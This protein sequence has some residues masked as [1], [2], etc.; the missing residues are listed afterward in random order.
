MAEKGIRL[1]PKHGVNPSVGICFYCGK[2]D[3]TVVLPGMLKGDVEA[4]REAVWTREPCADCKGWMGKGVILVG[5]RDGQPKSD[6]PDRSGHFT[7]ITEDGVRRAFPTEFADQLLKTRFGFIEESALRA[8][9]A[10]K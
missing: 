1:S 4:P 10:I 5:V 6:N 3:G 9:G 7:V 8:L 2:P